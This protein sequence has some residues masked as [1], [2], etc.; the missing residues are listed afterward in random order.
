M[1]LYF[2]L[3]CGLAAVA[4]G[5]LQRNWIL[6]RRDAGNRAH[7]RDFAAAI[8]QGAAAYL[9]RQYKTI[10]IVGVVLAIL[11]GIFLS[12]HHFGVWLRVGRFPVGCLRLHR[13]E[14]VGQGQR[15]HRASGD[16]RHWPSARCRIQR[17]CDHWDAGGRPRTV[18]RGR[19][20]SSIS[21]MTGST[22]GNSADI[23]EADARFRVRRFA[24]LD[25]RAAWRR[26]LHKRR[27]CRR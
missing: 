18:G 22:T 7:A 12:G 26:H 23:A 5:F 19:C 15:A 21:S 27:G 11:I 4:Y 3:A 20:S 6:W 9:A 13:H 2:A 14:C 1:A 16:P 25:L 17:W 10:A 8:Q 24:D